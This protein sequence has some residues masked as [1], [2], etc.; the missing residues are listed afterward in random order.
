MPQA[1]FAEIA[2]GLNCFFRWW[3]GGHAAH[4]QISLSLDTALHAGLT[5]AT[6]PGLV[7]VFAVEAGHRRIEAFGHALT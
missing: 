4:G 5:T 6:A 1:A 3:S 7:G 2:G